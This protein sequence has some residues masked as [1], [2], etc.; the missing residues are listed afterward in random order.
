MDVINRACELALLITL[1][2]ALG[3]LSLASPIVS[4]LFEHGAFL[5]GDTA[6]TANAARWLALALPGAALGKIF[7]QPFFARE[8]PALPSLAALA[9][10][11]ITLGIGYA[12]RERFGAGGIALAIAIAASAQAI[13]L[14]VFLHLQGYLLAP[15]RKVLWRAGRDSWPLALR[16]LSLFKSEELARHA[17]F[18]PRAMALG[19][20]LSCCSGSAPQEPSSSAGRVALGAVDPTYSAIVPTKASAA[21]AG[22]REAR[23]R[24]AQRRLEPR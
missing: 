20:A 8:R 21:P 9:V 1:P 14:G 6:E 10:V 18:S 11:V 3:L 17:P 2:A 23:G 7:A 19:C 15:A 5:R 22:E 16:W 4:V 24:E 13:S 12:L